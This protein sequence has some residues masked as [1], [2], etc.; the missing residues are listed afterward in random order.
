MRRRWVLLLVTIFLAGCVNQKESI[1]NTKAPPAVTST[2]PSARL[3]HPA[4]LRLQTIR[5]TIHP[6]PPQYYPR[7]PHPKPQ[8][9][10]QKQIRQHLTWLWLKTP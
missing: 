1:P 2:Q 6:Q 4:P 10:F 8:L 3:P 7:Q 5:T 9:K